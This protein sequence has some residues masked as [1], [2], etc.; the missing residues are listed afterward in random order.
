[1]TGGWSE[2]AEWPGTIGDGSGAIP[3]SIAMWVQFVAAA[4]IL[5]FL[6]PARGARR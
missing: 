5:V 1:M 4:G 3:P 6:L 2:N